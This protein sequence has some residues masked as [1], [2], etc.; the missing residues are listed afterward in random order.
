M[1]KIVQSIMVLVIG[2][3]VAF[4]FVGCSERERTTANIQELT[5]QIM[6]NYSTYFDANSDFQVVY[7]TNVQ[8]LIN[9]E[10]RAK[11]LTDYLLPIAKTGYA[12]YNLTKSTIS[13]DTWSEEDRINIYNKL[14]DL[15]TS[16]GTLN[17]TKSRLENAFSDYSGGTITNI[18]FSNLTNYIKEYGNFVNSLQS[19]IDVYKSAY[20]RNYN[21]EFYAYN[22]QNDVDALSLKI[23][24]ADKAYEISRAS[25]NLEYKEYYDI[26]NATFSDT[27]ASGTTTKMCLEMN[28][29][30]A[31]SS[32]A[33]N[34]LTD[35]TK[36]TAYLDLNN[37]ENYFKSQITLFDTAINA[38]DFEKMR[39]SAETET[40]YVASLSYQDRSNY[41]QIMYIAYSYIPQV[42]FEYQTVFNSF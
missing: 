8:T 17:N 33:N 40:A 34:T 6:T 4:A 14:N 16:F 3:S 10:A 25:Y 1:N 9:N 41:E 12:F 13:D 20:F 31:L 39:N 26:D 2:I 27:V 38:F 11:V 35:G 32:K 22:G 23:I 18:Q 19:F 15:N 7:S 24:L 28:K 29:V 5:S 30:L 37:S 42:V 36:K 21:T